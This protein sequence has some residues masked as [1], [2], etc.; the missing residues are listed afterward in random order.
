M[1]D[2]A[3]HGRYKGRSF[4]RSLGHRNFGK[5]TVDCSF[6]D[7]KSKWGKMGEDSVALLRLSLNLHEPAGYKLSS[8]ECC[9]RFLPLTAGPSP[10][11]TEYIYPD[12]L[13]GPPLA[14]R[15]SR[16]HN[17]EPTVEIMGTSIGGV[18]VHGSA[19]RLKTLRWHLRG[20]RLPDEENIY[21][22]ASWAWQANRLNEE[23]E[24]VR[25]F[26]LAVVLAHSEPS[27][28]VTLAIDGRLRRG[29]RKFKFGS[30]KAPHTATELELRPCDA[31]LS[32][33]IEGLAEEITRLNKCP[34]PRKQIA[35]EGQP[36]GMLYN[37]S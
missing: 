21:T 10:S 5:T 4:D 1:A 15:V 22:R 16:N 9:L 25:A 37:G 20:S 34:I 32:S 3:T 29:F 24:L 17:L 2:Q 26:Q 11:V 19:E 13:C 30:F 12:V 8:S 31:E 7:S 23:N 18:G 35:L 14:Q 36:F 6:L 33:V 27:I 28:G